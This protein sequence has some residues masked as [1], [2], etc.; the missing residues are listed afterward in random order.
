[1]MMNDQDLAKIKRLTEDLLKAGE[2][3][4]ILADRFARV[5]APHAEEL[6]ELTSEDEELQHLHDRLDKLFSKFEV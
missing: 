6:S 5:T 1:M 3:F 4:F 2:A